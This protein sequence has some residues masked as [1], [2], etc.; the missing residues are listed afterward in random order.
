MNND[1]I[2]LNQHEKQSLF[3][4]QRWGLPENAVDDL[5]NRLKRIWERFRNCFTTKTR[6]TSEY[7]LAYMR[8][9]LTMDTNRNYANIARKV[10]DHKDDGQNIQQFMS[11]SPWTASQVFDQ[12][13]SEIKRHNQLNGGMLTLDESGD[14]RSGSQSAGT[15]RQHIGRLGKVDMGQV[16]VALGYYRHLVYGRCSIVSARRMV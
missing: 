15:A 4:P 14:K 3:D 6:D 12:I 7:A 5:A 16:G 1:N 13:Q 9:L 11:D 10:I 2:A 8:G